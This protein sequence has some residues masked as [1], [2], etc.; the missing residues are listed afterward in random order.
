MKNL[1]II[2]ARMTSSRLPGKVMKKIQDTPMIKIL[3]DRLRKSN[4]IDQI[5]VATT[6]CKSDDILVQYLKKKK[7]KFYRGSKEN[8]VE[9]II[10]TATF[11]QAKNIILITGDCPLIDFNLVDQCIRTFKYNNV[12]FVTNSNI[13]S[14]PDG[15]DAQIFKKSTLIKYY[16]KKSKNIKEF[17]HVTLSMRKNIQK[18]KI[19]NIV[20]PTDQYFPKIGLT[21]DDYRDFKLIS[22][23]IKY[24]WNKNMK[25]FSCKEILDYLFKNKSLLQINKN[26]K[27]KGDN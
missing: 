22:K 8:V 7:I 27:R 20:S 26:V 24:F 17:E 4:L 13:R 19:I 21:L 12:E 10:K 25:F 3:Y 11:F 6:N 2:T 14:F 1:A 5:V 9:R 16:K 23:I 15:M 18:N